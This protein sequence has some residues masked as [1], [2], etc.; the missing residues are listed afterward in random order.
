MSFA[1]VEQAFNELLEQDPTNSRQ[2]A[3]YYQGEPVVD[4][5]GGP[6]FEQ[7]SLLPVFSSSKGT[8]G[9]TIGLLVERG[10]ID[11]DALVTDYWPEF[12][13]AGKSAVTVR[14]LFSHQAG[15][16]G[17]TGGYTDLELLEH[18]PLAK[19]L[20]AQ[21]PHWRPGSAF[22]YH[23]I[24]IGTLADELVRRITG[25][26]FSDYFT[27]EIAE[28]RDIDVHIGVPAELDPR[29]ADVD[30]PPME[31]LMEMLAKLV[32]PGNTPLGSLALFSSTKGS[33]LTRINDED[34]RRVGPPG[35]G[36]LA[37]ARGLA[38]MYAAVHHDLG[39]D[40]ILSDD[41]IEQ[42]SQVQVAGLDLANGQNARFAIAFQ[43]PHAERLEF[44]SYRAFGHDGA[45]GSLGFSDPH[46][47][48][49]FGYTVKRIP[50]PG[51]VDERAIKLA[52]VARNCVQ[53]L[54]NS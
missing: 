14:Q 15:L 52:A 53:A 23:A 44:G 35:A 1:P 39:S 25:R 17:P 49:A 4:L 26:T 6:G 20:A 12:G 5:V 2:L 48:I 19:R 41:T 46:Y 3:I 29:C 22:A 45:G 38:R 36:G 7:D 37:T 18:E 24:T 42:V 30:L 47:D 43:K 8:I 13:Q 10:L 51:G 16:H 9:L 21:R 32:D 54:R 31:E 34:F 28:P 11:L 40:R 50:L 27:N 33:L